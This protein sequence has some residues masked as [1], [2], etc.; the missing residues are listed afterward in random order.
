MKY[1]DGKL[2][3]LLETKSI[4]LITS[5]GMKKNSLNSFQKSQSLRKE[6]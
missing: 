6:N 2:R 3:R 4:V 5:I 1:L